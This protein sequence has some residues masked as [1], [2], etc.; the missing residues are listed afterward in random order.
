VVIDG[1]HNP[2]GAR[3][4]ARTLAEDFGGTAPGTLVVGMT[5]G[6]EPLEMLSELGAARARRVVACQPPTPRALDAVSIAEAARSL[7]VEADVVRDVSDAVRHAVALAAEDEL[8]LVTGS[9]YAV[10]EARKAFVH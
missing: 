2:A 8:V 10:G 1:A 9:L 7:G 6:R 4:V 3:A 5:Q